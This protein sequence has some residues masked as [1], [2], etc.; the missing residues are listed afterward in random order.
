MSQRNKRP[1]AVGDFVNGYQ[2]VE[3]RSGS[4]LLQDP[5]DNK[6]YEIFMNDSQTERTAVRT[7]I[8][9][10]PPETPPPAVGKAQR[11]PP[12]SA[13]VRPGVPPDPAAAP[14]SIRQRFEN[15]M[16]DQENNADPQQAED[17]M[18]DLQPTMP[19]L[20]ENGREELER[21]KR[22]FEKMRQ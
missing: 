13:K 4:V 3:I 18:E 12:R 9:Q 16:S 5:Y 19:A 15:V 21:L 1:Y 10:D 17:D 22:E 6:Q 7:E 20:D 2:V 8:V 11:M 14:D